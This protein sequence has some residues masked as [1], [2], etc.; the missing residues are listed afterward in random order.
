M[1][2]AIIHGNPVLVMAAAIAAVI[3][4]PATA[5][6]SGNIGTPA[7]I[8]LRVMPLNN[9]SRC[10]IAYCISQPAIA[11]AEPT[12]RPPRTGFAISSFDA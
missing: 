3:T 5:K 7:I 11:D 9:G 8:A 1:I 6:K 12:R 4:S 10:I 2:I